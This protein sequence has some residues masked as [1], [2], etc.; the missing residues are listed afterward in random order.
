MTRLFF[1]ALTVLLLSLPGFA[2]DEPKTGTTK[3]Q[4]QA[5]EKEFKD[6][7]EE[8]QKLRKEVKTQEEFD[9]LMSEKNPIPKFAD[10]FLSL[11]EKDPKDPVAGDAVFLVLRN[12]GTRGKNGTR[13]LELFPNYADSDKL[14]PIVMRLGGDVDPINEKLLKV[15]LEKNKNKEILG[16]ATY[17]LAS[18]YKELAEVVP[19][20]KDN[21]EIRKRAEMFFG[22]DGVKALLAR[23]V[24][25]LAKETEDL[26]D[27][28]VKKYAD[29]DIGRQN[30]GK[31]ASR[32]LFEMRDLQVGKTAPATE[33]ED[34][35][36]KKSS[37]AQ[38]KG[39]VV[40]LD[41]WATWCGPCRAMIPHERELVEK[42]KDKPFVFVSISA[43]EQKDTLKQFLTKE[44]MP[45]THWWA[46]NGGDES[47]ETI[48]EK[49]NIRAFPTL[50]LI[51]SKGVIRKKYVGSPQGDELDK[52]IAALV[53]E[54]EAK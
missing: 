18:F 22:A 15:V 37:I 12:G 30:L 25:T 11:A 19:L 9:K 10:K 6:A 1:G 21:E 26:Y 45:W 39:K 44:K 7:L 43:D 31:V 28:I 8:F 38:F 54:A 3:E 32:E 51:D 29:V 14:G 46:G 33:A 53:K 27:V 24:K 49:W 36:G 2:A 23:D 41:F 20:V 35:D 40:V 48:V 5:L 50:Y 47:K 16:Q 13:L 17:A 34:I 52:E 42:M 4:F